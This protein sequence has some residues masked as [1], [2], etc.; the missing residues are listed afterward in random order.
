MSNQKPWILSCDECESMPSD[1]PCPISNCS[2]HKNGNDIHWIHKNCGGSF[3][4]YENG[5]EK[6]QKCGREDYFCKWSYTC[7]YDEK[8]K[9]I[10]YSKIRNILGN[11]MGMDSSKISATALWNIGLS[12]KHQQEQ[13]P[14]CFDK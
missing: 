7:S 10:S 11:I 12:I 2:K 9:L 3:R 4:L 5:I 6:C 13:F 14:E 8:N 1:Y